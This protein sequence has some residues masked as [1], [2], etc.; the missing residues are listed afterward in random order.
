[1]SYVTRWE[2][3][4]MDNKD[5]AFSAP[6][7]IESSTDSPKETAEGEKVEGEEQN[8]TV[9]EEKVEKKK[10]KTVTGTIG[11]YDKSKPYRD[12]VKAKVIQ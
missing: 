3:K 2:W 4:T 9:E 5:D 10:Q 6:Y 8:K 11:H 7:T 12:P 1:M